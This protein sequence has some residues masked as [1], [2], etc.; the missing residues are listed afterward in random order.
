MRN[1]LILIPAWL[2]LSG[3]SAMPEESLRELQS[4]E[5]RRVY[6][7]SPAADLR[8]LIMSEEAREHMLQQALFYAGRNAPVDN[9]AYLFALAVD[10]YHSLPP[11]PDPTGYEPG[12]L[13]GK[14]EWMR[15]FQNWLDTDRR[16]IDQDSDKVRAHDEQSDTAAASA[17]IKHIRH[18]FQEHIQLDDF[19]EHARLYPEDLSFPNPTHYAALRAYVD[20]MRHGIR[21]DASD[22]ADGAGN[23]APTATGSPLHAPGAAGSAIPIATAAPE[24]ASD[25]P[26]FIK[27]ATGALLVVAIVLLIRRHGRG[28]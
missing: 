2:V 18:Y 8:Q 17:E 10:L 25:M 27:W 22:K 21:S 26:S 24:K 3:V 12:E 20:S 6:R 16:D 13:G 19:I 7:E 14:G 15:W 9:R 11:G 28:G 5:L 23:A 1:I 4:E